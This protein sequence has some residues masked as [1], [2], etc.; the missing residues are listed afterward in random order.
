LKCRS[1]MELAEEV[2]KAC[3]CAAIEDLGRALGLVKHEKQVQSV[4]V[5]TEIWSQRSM[6]NLVPAQNTQSPHMI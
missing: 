4:P 5:D 1:R 2:V 3:S 6:C